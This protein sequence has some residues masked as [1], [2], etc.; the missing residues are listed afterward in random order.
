MLSSVGNGE[1]SGLAVE[2]KERRSSEEQLNRA[3]SACARQG[4]QFTTLRRKVLELIL[5]SDTPATAYQLLDRLKETRNAAPPTIY[6]AL[7]FLLDQRLIH[8][9]ERLSAFI[10]CTDTVHDH[11]HSAQ[12]LICRECGAVTE[13]ENQGISTAIDDA[14]G[15]EG[16]RVE[17]AVVELEGLCAL[18]SRTAP[19]VSG[20]G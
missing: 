18:C 11:R 12:L 14:A 2:M 6:R 7:E 5:E 17:T 1:C 9:V 13:I 4:V 10:P 19:A 20:V 3:A 15:R 16:F 8:K